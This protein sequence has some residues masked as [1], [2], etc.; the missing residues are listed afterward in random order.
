MLIHEY[1]DVLHCYKLV[2]FLHI[3]RINNSRGAVVEN[4]KTPTACLSANTF[5]ALN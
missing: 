2:L 1:K 3:V 4:Y 5:L